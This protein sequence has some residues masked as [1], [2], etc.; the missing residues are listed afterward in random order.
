MQSNE[1]QGPEVGARE[2]VKCY[3]AQSSIPAIVKRTV[4]SLG[5]VHT[6]FA[7]LD[8]SFQLAKL[9]E[10]ASLSQGLQACQPSRLGG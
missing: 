7:L 4:D 9:L 2:L 1:F 8:P 6:N 10:T 3:K 5:H